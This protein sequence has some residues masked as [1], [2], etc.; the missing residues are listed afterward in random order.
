MYKVKVVLIKEIIHYIQIINNCFN[1]KLIIKMSL[2]RI[3]QEYKIN[4]WINKIKV[5]SPLFKIKIY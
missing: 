3:F 2:K 5:A 1:D 4:K